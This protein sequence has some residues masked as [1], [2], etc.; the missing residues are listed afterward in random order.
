MLNS[1]NLRGADSGDHRAYPA[2]PLQMG[3]GEAD[4]EI[5]RRRSGHVLPRGTRHQ[6]VQQTHNHHSTESPEIRHRGM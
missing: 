1:L 2:Q 6:S 5:L 3:Q 4:G